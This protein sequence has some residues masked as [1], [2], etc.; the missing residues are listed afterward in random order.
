MKK[1][2]LLIIFTYSFVSQ[3]QIKEKSTYFIGSISTTFGIN[4][5]YNLGEEDN[6]PFIVPK[7]IL[8]R[9]EFGYQFDKRWASSFNI[10][11][12]HHFLYSINAV[13]YYGSVR[14]N[15]INKS[16]AAYFIEGSYGKMWRPSS[17]FSNGDYYKLGI[18]L[19]S[20]SSSRWNGVVKLDF[21]RK[22]IVGFK[23]GNLDSISL[24]IGF[25]F[26]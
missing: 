25:S 20:I 9:T 21:H 23:N 6:G 24:G 3:S 13:P 14:Y 19:M 16:S 26:F 10:G 7:A 11:Y 1:L 22:K 5:D 17:K 2:L 8:L 15:F 18:G 4:Q 12:D